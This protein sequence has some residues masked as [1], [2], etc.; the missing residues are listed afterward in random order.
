MRI[1]DWS[2]DVCSSD[3]TQLELVVDLEEVGACA[4]HFVDEGQTGHPV[5]IGLA[6]YCFGLRLHAAHGAVH[7]AGTVEHTH[8]TFDL[9]RE[10][11]VTRGVDDVDTVFLVLM[12]HAGPE[13]SGRGGRALRESLD[14]RR[15]RDRTSTR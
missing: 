10:V 1:S 3:L 15:C 4:V 14:D 8:G 2:S 5:F 13:R 6:P 9:D 7:H 11:N 12:F